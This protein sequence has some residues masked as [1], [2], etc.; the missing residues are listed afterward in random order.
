M[1]RTK[2]LVGLL[3][4][5]LI[6]ACVRT[7]SNSE[8]RVSS[9]P[10]ETVK[11]F[12]EASSAAKDPADKKRLEGYCSGEMRQAFE[13]MPDDVFRLAYLGGGVKITDIK[14]LETTTREDAAR[15]R[16][17]VAVENRQGSDPTKE[18][19]EREVDLSKKDGKWFISVIRMKG[20]DQIAFTNG[21]IF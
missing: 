4:A 6:G 9:N 16:Y 18:I 8:A 19:N 13:K 2:I 17:Q 21:M 5:A 11:N 3:V 20:S 12:L 7:G 1:P 15:V 14:V 10:E